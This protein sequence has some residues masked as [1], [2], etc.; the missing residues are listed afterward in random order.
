MPHR[1]NL[2]Y[3]QTKALKNL[4]DKITEK[5]MN[6]IGNLEQEKCKAAVEKFGL[7]TTGKTTGRNQI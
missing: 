1:N 7:V 5:I 3:Q 4:E 2:K 6:N